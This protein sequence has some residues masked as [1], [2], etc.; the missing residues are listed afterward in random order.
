MSSC[1]PPSTNRPERPR[2]LSSKV[3]SLLTFAAAAGVLV[4]EIAAGRLLA[5]YVGISLTTYTGIIGVILAGIAVGAW[6]GGRAADRVGPEPLIGPTLLA[7]G[8]AGMASVPVVA[9]V[10]PVNPSGDLGSIVVLATI[11]FFAPAAILSAVAPMIVRAV[12]V[13]IRSSGALVGRLSAVGTAG[14]ITGTFLTGFFLLGVVPTR[15]LILATGGLLAVVG[16]LLTWWLS[17]R[18]GS[19]ALGVAALIAVGGLSAALPNPCQRESRYYCIAVIPDATDP[20]GRLLVLDNLWHAYVDLD[21]PAHLEFGYLRWFAAATASLAAA[22]GGGFRALHVGGGGFTFPR[23][24]ASIA[25]AGRHVIL[26]L[27]PAILALA[28]EELGFR[29]DERMDVVLGDARLTIAGQ[30]DDAFDLVVGDAFGGLSVPWHLTTAEFLA[31]VDRVLRP[32]GRYV[33]NLIDQQGLRFVRAEA[34]TLRTRFE[35]VA[36]LGWAAVLASSTGPANVVLVASHDDFAPSDLAEAIQS[37]GAAV[38]AGDPALD[39]FVAGASVLTDDFAP[40]DQLIGR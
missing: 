30:P 18:R 39:T 20:S 25:P 16:L 23:Y 7:G 37:L 8:L 32:D 4:L 40:V 26:E 35:H 33:M 15:L 14:A 28:R 19:A 3:A 21:D 6:L 11:G 38:I 36:V 29:P 13:D 24:L 1:V 34:A 27:D 9:A 2:R 17:G 10:G 5:P 12:I 22:E 31:E